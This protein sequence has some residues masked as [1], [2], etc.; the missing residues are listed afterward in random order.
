MQETPSYM[1]DNLYAGNAV[2]YMIPVSL[3]YVP[4]IRSFS[5]NLGLLLG[6]QRE[7]RAVVTPP[8]QY[9]SARAASQC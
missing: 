7:G 9:R 4:S 1:Q 2:G 8:F 3:C 5:L 6:L